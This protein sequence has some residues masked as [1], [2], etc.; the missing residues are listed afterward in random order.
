MKE[1]YKRPLCFCSTAFLLG[2]AIG[3]YFNVHVAV[4]LSFV[5]S[6]YVFIA[7]STVTIIYRK[8]NV[9]CIGN[10]NFYRHIKA[11]TALSGALFIGVFLS[12]YT[13]FITEGGMLQHYS[14]SGKTI[15]ATVNARQHFNDYSASYHITI[16]EIDGEKVRINTVLESDFPLDFAPREK[17]ILTVSL[18]K[19][20]GYDDSLFSRCHARSKGI[21]F[22]AVP[23]EDSNYQ[24]VGSSNSFS[25]RLNEMR[26]LMSAGIRHRTN[27]ESAG[28]ISALL[29]GD[30]SYLSESAERDFRRLGLSHV[31]AISGMHLSIIASA[32]GFILKKVRLPQKFRSAIT[33][34]VIL[35]YTT[36]TGFSMSVL[37]ATLMLIMLTAANIFGRK[38]DPITSLLFS[39]SLICLFDIRA[40]CD[41]GLTLSFSATLGITTAGQRA[42][43]K[44]DLFSS[45]SVFKNLPSFFKAPI[46]YIMSSF[47]VSISAVFFTLPFSWIWFGELSL[48]SPLSN[49]IFIPLFQILMYVIPFILLHPVMPIAASVAASIATFISNV[50][51]SLADSVARHIGLTISL[52]HGFT[53]YI[54]AISLLLFVFLM[55]CKKSRK[56]AFSMTALFLVIS[57]TFG[58]TASNVLTDSKTNICYFKSNI[59]EF[60]I[61]SDKS[62]TALCDISDG[63]RSSYTKVMNF[64]KNELH[65]SDIETLIIT[66]YHNRHMTTLSGLSKKNY[67]KNLFLSVPT[68]DKEYS[69]AF[70]LCKAAE[71][72]GISVTFYRCLSDTTSKDNGAE[73]NNTDST[74][75]NKLISKF[76]SD[77]ISDSTKFGKNELMLCRREYITRSTHP[78]VS[79]AIRTEA[80]SGNIFYI[81]YLA[82]SYKDTNFQSKEFNL[83][84]QNSDIT[85]YGMHSPKSTAKDYSGGAE[86]YSSND[87][88]FRVY[89]E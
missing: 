1:F 12:F 7:S 27:K 23:E 85:V 46:F 38:S 20:E 24:I 75:E 32:L 30:R 14:G 48:I 63:T 42:L 53:P 88:F 15:E 6:A 44:I 39:V 33:I 26:S 3:G 65:K 70:T 82:A 25:G 47:A 52:D 73:N 2:A 60:F 69:I 61:V 71:Q 57:M 89:E 16:T 34:S 74:Y 10:E 80:K 84:A 29:I 67:I 59:N 35:L 64:I 87:F 8:S 4:L 49:L 55:I 9:R 79:L 83:I 13:F 62:G 81:T 37:R 54:L 22:T 77:I 50:I 43:N 17:V 66:H 19:Y 86:E 58:I 76:G 51:S 56:H 18:S 36:L 45:N 78:V 28:M 72:N 5:I 41:V 21:I 11:L 40:V 68:T 31:L